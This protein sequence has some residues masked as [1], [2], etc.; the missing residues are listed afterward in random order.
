[1]H[2]MLEQVHIVKSPEQDP[3]RRAVRDL[4]L[5]MREWLDAGLFLTGGTDDPAVYYD[6]EKPFLPPYS[7]LTNDTLAG[8]LLPGQEIT[9]EEMLRMFTINGAYSCFQENI[10][11][12]LEVGKLADMTVLDRDILTCATEEVRDV[13]VLQTYVGGE[14]AFEKGA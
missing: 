8:V 7:T 5:P 11:G 14:L 10:R 9:R 3:W 4:G 2:H 6:V 12:S 1:M 13:E